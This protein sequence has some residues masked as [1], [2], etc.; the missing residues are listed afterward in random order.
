MRP[1]EGMPPVPGAPD[2]G[3]ALPHSHYT[4]NPYIRNPYIRIPYIRTP[5]ARTLCT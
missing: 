5:C 4:C 3:M 2:S 1:H